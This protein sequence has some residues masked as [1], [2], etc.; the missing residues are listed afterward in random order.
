M[1]TATVGGHDLVRDNIP[2]ELMRYYR[3]I[4]RVIW[5]KVTDVSGTIPVNTNTDRSVDIE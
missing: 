3:A 2:Y 4:R 5:L 1:A